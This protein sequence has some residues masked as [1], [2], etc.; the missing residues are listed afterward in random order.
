MKKRILL[1]LLI[2][3]T[4]LFCSCGK[5][6]NQPMNVE[7][8]KNGSFEAEVGTSVSDWVID[9]YSVDAPI[10][11][12]KVVADDTAPEGNN[13]IMINSPEFNDARFIQTVPVAPDSYYRLSARVK[14]ENIEARSA[15][16]GANICFLQTHCK[17]EYITADTDW[18]EVVIFGKT[19]SKMTEATVAL[20]LGYYSADASGIV[21]FDDVSLTRVDSVPAG[22]SAQS[23]SGITFA[24]S[25]DND[26]DSKSNLSGEKMQANVTMTGFVLFLLLGLFLIWAYKSLNFKFKDAYILIGIALVVRLIASFMYKGFSVDINCFSYWGSKMASDGLSGF[27]E[28]GAFCDYP[29]LYMIVLG[30]ISLITKPFSL[31]LQEGFGLVMLKLPAVLADVIAAVMIMHVSKKH[32]GKKIAALLGIGYALLPT[33]IVNSA[34]WGQVDSI[35][36]LFMLLTFYLIDEDKFGL[37]VL[38]FFIGLLLKPQ[39]VLFGP[40]ML[41]AAAREFYVIF[42]AFKNDDNRDALMRLAKGFGFLLISLLI[43]L[44]LSILMQNDQSP[45]WLIDKYLDTIGSYDYATLSS[46]GL[47]GLLGGQWQPSDTKTI[48]DLTYSQLGTILLAV[49]M[50]LLVL[51]FLRQITRKTVMG[52]RWF[53]LLS[54]FMLAGAVTFSTRTHERYMFPVIAML[55]MSYVRFK[56]IKL[57]FISFGYAF[58]NF[59]NVTALLFLY[60][61][62]GN[63]YFSADDAIF[64]IGSGLTVILFIYQTYLTI[65]LVLAGDEGT[66]TITSASASAAAQKTARVQLT[67]SLFAQRGS[68]LPKIKLKDVIICLL[69]TAIYSVFAF[70]NLG[71]TVSAETYWYTSKFTPSVVLDLGEVTE[72]DSIH[73]KR[74]STDGTFRIYL[75]E[76]GENYTTHS[77]ANTQYANGWKQSGSEG[78]KARYV[79]IETLSK[80]S[81]RELAIIKDD[82]PIEIKS[83]TVSVVPVDNAT[84]DVSYLFDEQDSWGKSDLPTS[85]WASG[86]NYIVTFESPVVIENIRAH[87]VSGGDIFISMPTEVVAD[88]ELGGDWAEVAQF[89]TYDSGWITPSY[90]QP[91]SDIGGVDKILISNESKCEVSELVFLNGTPKI[92]SVTDID[93][94]P[95]PQ[96]FM[97]LFDEAEM[98]ATSLD[99]PDWMV[100]SLYD[101]LLL[102]LGAV[103]KLD[104]GYY[105]P[106]L[107][108]GTFSAYYSADGLTWSSRNTV[109]VEKSNLYTW[110]KIDTDDEARYVLL[111]AESQFLKLLE[112]GFFDSSTAEAPVTIASA[113]SPNSTATAF[114]DEQTLVPHEGPTYMNGM[115]FDE[116]YHARTAYESANG[117]S[118]YEWTHP[119]LGKDFISWSVSTLGMNPFAWRLPGVMAGILMVPAIYFLAL[120]LFKKTSWATLGAIL[121]AFD[122][123]H[124]VQTRIATIDSFGVLFIILMFLFMYWYYSMSFYDEP[125]GKTFI[126]LGLCG[127]SFGLGAASKWICLYAGAGLA[128]IF[129][130]TLFRRWREYVAAC[131]ALNKVSGEEKLYYQHIKDR[132]VLNTCYTILFCILVFIIIPLIIYCAS[133]YPYWNAVGE[134]RKWYEIIIDNQKAMFDYHSQLTATHYYQ[135]DWFTWPI[136]YKPMFYYAGPSDADTIYAIYAFGNP[137]VW[138]AGLVATVTAIVIYVKRFFGDRVVNLHTT[139][140]AKGFFGLFTPGDESY[141]NVTLVDTRTLTFL[142]IGLAANLMPW[143]GVS[144]CVFIYHYFA[145]VPFIVLFT[146]YV[147]RELS[148]KRL[149]AAAIMAIVLAI[150]AVV[151]FI[152]YLPLWTG[153][154]IS[155]DFV[156]RCLRWM[157]T[158][159]GYY[160]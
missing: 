35:L 83:S 52:T 137:A 65:R 63:I 129:F 143:V 115:Y 41:L 6:A 144:R 131:N 34:L 155:K 117:L 142:I 101:Y 127:L 22:Y 56:D 112:I 140:Q 104:R 59:V 154:A 76:D 27:Y 125:L 80:V 62:C 49:V 31:N 73:Y 44:L 93:G 85:T 45:Q 121:F 13:V 10:E 18:T 82:A 114:V 133:Y 89:F 151:L 23:M 28:Q 148:R 11:Y 86:G 66:R 109:K 21:Y 75:S 17:S 84:T 3:A 26:S 134:S 50:V 70:S 94:N 40:V 118:I 159:F 46:F 160:F 54:A 111:T 136:M 67:S 153:T 120:L 110:Q 152:A 81:I 47:M 149:K 157:S 79:K 68:T 9:R 108:E 24:A 77:T 147:L 135:S 106:S 97:N 15:T 132:F 156:G 113:T 37:G 20:R 130:M 98:S 139:L 55:I 42:L 141:A 25:D 1:I 38:V 124:Y 100:T 90:S 29:P 150:V 78:G 119:P 99:K 74:G 138:Y 103:T 71:D 64:L 32:V 33:A 122:G 2:I 96:D 8:I 88:P 51:M 30:F 126:P 145:S 12:Y 43:F 5:N 19:D 36:V 16:S 14:T 4:L 61:E 105:M 91:T 39:A 48:F 58:L 95:A 69:I 107:C 92:K 57:L 116:I 158:W 7:L 72:F 102:D 87:F 53:W 123:M 146:V 128:V 60:E